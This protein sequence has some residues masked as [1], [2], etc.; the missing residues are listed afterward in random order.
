MRF[1]ATCNPVGTP[2]ALAVARPG[3]PVGLGLAGLGVVGL[4][5]AG[6]GARVAVAD[7]TIAVDAAGCG[8][9]SQ[10][11]AARRR[12]APRSAMSGKG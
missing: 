7:A 1:P 10:P 4:G 9:R 8:A 3:D 2:A 5:V 11:A 6:W 12:A